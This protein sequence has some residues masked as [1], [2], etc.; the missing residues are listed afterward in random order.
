MTDIIG[1]SLVLGDATAESDTLMTDYVARVMINANGVKADNAEVSGYTA[2]ANG[3]S[4]IY[5]PNG[6]SMAQIEE[7]VAVREDL[8]EAKYEDTARF[9]E[10][11]NKEI[12]KIEGL[13]SEAT[14]SITIGGKKLVATYTGAELAEGVDISLDKN[15]PS[16]IVASK[17]LDQL[18]TKRTYI[19][20]LRSMSY[21]RETALYKRGVDDSVAT[22]E[23]IFAVLDDIIND[24]SSSSY[25]KSTANSYKENYDI[26]HE[27]YSTINLCDYNVKKLLDFDAYEVV[28]EKVN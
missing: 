2:N 4:F 23:E 14:Y 13:E 10:N 6:V 25:A 19:A 20:K 11:P 21:V 17:I 7:L 24:K 8:G 22:R 15:N 12:F 18:Y 28:V 9:A 5:K 27:F 1:K 16:A 3:V 26:Q